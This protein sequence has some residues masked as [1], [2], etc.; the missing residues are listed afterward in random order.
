MA[1]HTYR[2]VPKAETV[3]KKIELPK[4][5]KEINLDEFIKEEGRKLGI[6]PY[7]YYP[8]VDNYYERR[9]LEGAP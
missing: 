5:E 6:D 4:I 1:C 8:A 3:E 2:I 7:A 9:R